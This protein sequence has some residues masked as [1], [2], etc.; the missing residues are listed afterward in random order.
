M[1]VPESPKANAVPAADGMMSCPVC[2]RRLSPMAAA[3]PGCGHPMSVATGWAFDKIERGTLVR[4]M[5][6]NGQCAEGYFQQADATSI[7][8]VK[9]S[10]LAAHL[11]PDRI[12]CVEE[13]ADREA[14]LAEVRRRNREFFSDLFG[15]CG[16][17]AYSDMTESNAVIDTDSILGNGNFAVTTDRGDKVQCKAFAVGYNDLPAPAGHRIMVIDNPYDRSTSLNAMV[18]MTFSSLLAIFDRT[19]DTPADRMPAAKNRIK[20]IITCLGR[21]PRFSSAN[22]SLPEHLNKMRD[23]LDTLASTEFDTIVRRLKPEDIPAAR[24]LK[25]RSAE[26]EVEEAAEEYNAAEEVKKEEATEKNTADGI[27][28]R[29]VL[30]G[31]EIVG[32]IDLSGFDTHRISTAPDSETTRELPVMPPADA[33]DGA[34]GSPALPEIFSHPGVAAYFD[35]ISGLPTLTPE[36]ET[37]LTRR[38]D[39]L[40]MQGLKE[41]F[42]TEVSPY[43]DSYCL[44]MPVLRRLAD[45]MYNTLGGMKRFEEA[46]KWN[47]LYIL[48]LRNGSTA[49][50]PLLSHHFTI[51]A[52]YYMNLGRLDEAEKAI[53]QAEYHD[54]HSKDGRTSAIK[55]QRLKLESKMKAKGVDRDSRTPAIGSESL[56]SLIGTLLAT[57]V[58]NAA[59]DGAAAT[60]AEMAIAGF[61]DALEGVREIADE[62]LIDL[63]ADT[64]AVI[65]YCNRQAGLFLKTAA[66]FDIEESDWLKTSALYYAFFKGRALYLDVAGVIEGARKDDG[67]LTDRYNTALAYLRNVPELV[68]NKSDKMQ[69]AAYQAA[70]NW[71][72]NL[73]V[74]ATLYDGHRPVPRGWFRKT[75]RDFAQEYITAQGDPVEQNLLRAYVSAA[76][77]SL[78]SRSLLS[79]ADTTGMYSRAHALV[80]AGKTDALLSVF[81][82]IG[83]VP[84]NRQPGVPTGKKLLQSLLVGRISDLK[85]IDKLIERVQ[86]KEL[87]MTAL[88]AVKDTCD[89]TSEYTLSTTDHSRV[90]RLREVL[91]ALQAF[92]LATKSEEKKLRFLRSQDAALDEI[93]NEIALYGSD[94]SCSKTL[95]LCLYVKKGIDKLM[96]ELEERNYPIITV[97]ATDDGPYIRTGGDGTQYVTFSIA[98]LGK[99]AAQKIEII[100]DCPGENGVSESEYSLIEISER[101]DSQASITRRFAIPAVR[102]SI[103]LSFRGNVT[104]DSN[105]SLPIPETGMTFEV[106]SAEALKNSDIP[107]DT[108]KIPQEHM[109]KG[110]REILEQL[111]KHYLSE[112]RGSSYILYGLTRTGKSSILRYISDKLDGKQAAG[113]TIISLNWDLSVID[114]RTEASPWPNLVGTKIL[115]ALYRSGDEGKKALFNAVRER[116]NGKLPAT[117]SLSAAD[118]ETVVDVLNERGFLPFITVDEFSYVRAWLKADKVSAAFVKIMRQM[119]IEGKACF[120]YAGTYDIRRMANDAALGMS[121]NLNATLAE[122]ISEISREGAD[123]LINACPQLHFD[124]DARE[125]IRLQSGCIPYWIQ[126]ICLNCGK[127]AHYNNRHYLGRDEVEHVIG[128]MVGAVRTGDCGYIYRIDKGNFINN[129]IDPSIECEQWLLSCICEVLRTRGTASDNY[130]FSTAEL[131]QLWDEYSVSHTERNRM[132]RALEEMMERR[133]ILQTTTDN[134]VLYRLSVDLFR[135]WWTNTYPDFSNTAA[136]MRDASRNR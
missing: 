18:Q 1:K 80:A 94:F 23:W 88:K 47:A 79:E 24:P 92:N 32:R 103:R 134:G 127:Y 46:L 77:K 115:S 41:E 125:F 22:L 26:E 34:D 126:W 54:D 49:R 73:T 60:D 71:I 5:Y 61:E 50:D 66:R 58:G 33:A 31:P 83:V 17:S 85:N 72:F 51:M 112:A 96:R 44:S 132:N 120:V 57:D 105:S 78:Q 81:N 19:F 15:R 9:K 121:G 111:E 114:L 7:T 40:M 133:V 135:R 28:G 62:D 104:T 8:L 59:A 64:D 43:L 98:N 93:H 6:N 124:N 13:I 16:I 55:N 97:T 82:S 129:Q 27:S 101:L 67:H 56:Q 29:P 11:R 65:G 128:I 119:S 89:K 108:T 14:M 25:D 116:Y 118:F 136:E 122:H 21:D 42:V 12:V 4:V 75:A 20:T 102:N 76:E 52:G 106:P 45:A 107:W 100:V 3:C 74:A 38:A 86:Y 113:R 30:P 109:F 91:A 90:T 130:S 131:R 99:K 69:K 68:V 123:Q 110:R 84:G 48:V 70:I 53:R 87:D 63:P 2:G 37:K 36:E 117:G 39:E 10:R 95:P 35:K